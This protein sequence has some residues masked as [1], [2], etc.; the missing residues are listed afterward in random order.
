MTF[1]TW[2]SA[3][4][5]QSVLFSFDR[6]G[7]KRHCPTPLK[8][9]DL[10]HKRGIITGATS[11]IGLAAAKSLIAQGMQCQLIG[12][13]KEKL[14]PSLAP[15]FHNLD[16]GDLKKVLQYAENEAPFEIDLLIHNAGGMPSALTLT[17]EGY[18]AM[19]ASQ[20]LGPYL[21]TKRLI[22]LGK[23]KKGCRVIFVSSGGMYLQKLDLTDLT[24][25]KSAYNKYTGYA[26]AKRA[27]VILCELLAK[28]YPEYLFSAMHPGWADTPGVQSAMPLFRR[29]IN[30][31]L[32]S[33]EEGADT[34][35]WLATLPNY[36]SG[37]F[38][39]DRAEAETSI[40]HLFTPTDD[41]K[42]RLWEL[43]ESTYPST[44]QG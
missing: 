23:L 15:L 17:P 5:D 8:S 13:N 22:E 14:D 33:A 39:F 27:Q 41:D 31:R 9:V 43:C 1:K 19:F 24:F 3:L 20:V 25:Q 40:Y 42:K 34:L 37:K 44:R 16:M 35:I 36:P 38:W 4:L 10:T 18:E 11:G 30:T 12:R 21:L 7:Y 28:H 2:F 32:R 6:T 29:F 26:N